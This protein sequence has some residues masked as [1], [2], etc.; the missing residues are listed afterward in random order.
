M[1]RHIPTVP[2]PLLGSSKHKVKFLL[3]RASSGACHILLKPYVVHFLI[4]VLLRLFFPPLNFSGLLF[5]VV[6]CTATINVE[7]LPA[8]CQYQ[9]KSSII[10]AVAEH[11]PFVS[12]NGETAQWFLS[13]NNV[14][15]STVNYPKGTMKCI[16]QPIDYNVVP[17]F[18]IGLP[19]PN[20]HGAKAGLV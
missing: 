10:S 20:F 1:R 4:V 9:D 12:D 15:V 11:P 18:K 8:Q 19:Y 14:A 17:P 2:L 3:L 5:V 13:L 6:A 7:N 16:V